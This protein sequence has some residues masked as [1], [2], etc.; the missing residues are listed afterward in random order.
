[1][2][3]M[4]KDAPEMYKILMRNCRNDEHWAIK[5]WHERYYGRVKE[6]VDMNLTSITL[7]DLD[8]M[9]HEERII[10]LKNLDL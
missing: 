9:T 3:L 10:A 7:K 6:Q 2:G 1:M 8:S 4:E 5:I